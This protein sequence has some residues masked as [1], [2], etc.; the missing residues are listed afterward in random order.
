MI[1]QLNEQEQLLVRLVLKNG[2]A[3]NFNT[4]VDTVESMVS[5]PKFLKMSDNFNDI[6]VSIDDV[7]AFEVLTYRRPEPSGNNE[8]PVSEPA[9]V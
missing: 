9:I 1:E 5:H 3:F 4:H 2:H 8:A 6:F 7:S